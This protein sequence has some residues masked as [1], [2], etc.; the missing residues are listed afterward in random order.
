M[1]MYSK[2]LYNNVDLVYLFMVDIVTCLTVPEYLS[3]MTTDMFR[4]L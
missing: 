4:L 2:H 1:K 3:H